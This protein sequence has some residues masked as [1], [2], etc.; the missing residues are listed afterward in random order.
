MPQV[1]TLGSATSDI[2]VLTSETRILPGVSATCEKLV[3]F[4]LGAKI[5]VG[6]IQSGIGGAAANVAIGL[7]R[8]GI[9]VKPCV[10]LGADEIGESIERTFQKEKISTDLCHFVNGKGSDQSVI[11]VEPLKRD[12]TVF[13][14][15]EAGD[16]L[17]L[18]KISQWKTEWLFISSLAGD[19]KGKL[20]QILKLRKDKGVKIAW[21]PGQAQ[22]QAGVKFLAPLLRETSLLFLNWDEALDLALSDPIFREKYARRKPPQKALLRFLR[23]TGAQVSIVTLGRQGSLAVDES[24]FYEAPSLMTKPVELTGAGDAYASG[25]LASWVKDLGNVS[26]AMSWGV[27]NAGSVVLYFGAQKGLLTEK[28]IEKKFNEIL[29]D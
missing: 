17:R 16:R 29:A 24:G 8:L 27:A 14:S 11:L 25:F 15:R 18:N 28:K 26:R 2:F 12:R 1:I 10:A 20:S 7:C 13:Y 22:I 3:A 4:E 9:E 19:W 21:N 23:E 6:R 5:P